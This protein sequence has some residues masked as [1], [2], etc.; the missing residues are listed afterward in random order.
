MTEPDYARMQQELDRQLNDPTVTMEP[1]KIWALLA[2]L[3]DLP[4]T[5]PVAGQAGAFPP[6]AFHL[7]EDG[8]PEPWPAPPQTP[9][10]ARPP[11]PR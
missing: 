9:E 11:E 7:A 2:E 4:C 10:G 8:Q 5:G 3:A 1:A 6:L